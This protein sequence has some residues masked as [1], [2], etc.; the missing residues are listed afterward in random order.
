MASGKK[1]YGC[2]C[3]FTTIFFLAAASFWTLSLALL[4]GTPAT[5]DTI[6]EAIGTV[7]GTV[8]AGAFGMVIA[9][10]LSL[11]FLVLF[12]IWVVKKARN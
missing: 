10:G 9:L 11:V 7:V 6:G 12:I 5:A 4:Y 2:L 3:F 8:L 1:S